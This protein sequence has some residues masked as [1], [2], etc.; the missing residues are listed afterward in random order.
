MDTPTYESEDEVIGPLP[1]PEHVE[2]TVHV[3]ENILLTELSGVPICMLCDRLMEEDQPQCELHCHHS[4]HTFC[5]MDT[6]FNDRGPTICIVCNQ[7]VFERNNT[8]YNNEAQV[9]IHEKKLAK[10]EQKKKRLEEEVLGNKELMTDLKLVKKA[11]REARKAGAAFT[12]IQQ[13]QIRAFN[14]EAET[15]KQMLKGMKEARIRT[16]Q[17]SQE[18]KEYRSKRARAA[19]F[20]RA[21]ERKYPGKSMERLRD[22]QKLRLPSRWELGRILW[23]YGKRYYWRMR[24][25]I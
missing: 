2:N 20:I 9:A 14:E 15:M 24:V 23:G 19:F 10:R 3:P 5:I 12:K 11:I 22:I 18:C 17:L 7:Y 25:R 1:A 21:F 13:T 4:F 6:I 16:C 8:Q